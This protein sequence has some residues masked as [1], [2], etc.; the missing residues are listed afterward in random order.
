MWEIAIAVLNLVAQTPDII[1]RWKKF[2]SSKLGKGKDKMDENEEFMFGLYKELLIT[3]IICYDLVGAFRKEH[4]MPQRL[5]EYCQTEAQRAR[6]EL[7]KI[8]NAFKS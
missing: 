4:S 8:N 5:V 1:E 6:E 3:R 7:E 2:V